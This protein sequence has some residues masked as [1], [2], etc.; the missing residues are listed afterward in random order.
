MSFS[1]T[2]VIVSLGKTGTGKSATGNTILGNQGFREGLSLKSVTE[3]CIRHDAAPF[4]R[5]T[6]VID[7]P[8]LFGTTEN[9]DELKREIEKCVELSLPGPHAFLLVIRLD[10]R[11]TEE[12]KNAVKWI[13]E[14][15]GEEAFRYTIILL[16]HGDALGAQPVEHYLSTA[17]ALTTLIRQC[18][19]RYHVFD[20]NSQD[21][22]QVRGL[23]KKIDVMVGRN[24]G[25]HYSSEIYRAI[26]W[27]IR[28]MTGLKVAG[29]C[30]AGA[31]A[32]VA[33]AGSGSAQVAT[34]AIVTLATAAGMMRD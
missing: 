13:Q 26:Q 5:Q 27:R 7:T 25:E 3:T 17:P 33:A 14:T 29:A 30:A 20:N 31:V 4:G 15:F 23:L 32:V 8:G 12:E 10:V 9:Q 1:E 11:F 34:A 28:M 24:G 16:T 21:T 19:G 22:T 6:A 18:S 2:D